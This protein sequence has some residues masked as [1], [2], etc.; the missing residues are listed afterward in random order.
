M[1]QE[2]R[3][4]ATIV[5]RGSVPGRYHMDHVTTVYVKAF[6]IWSLVQ[7]SAFWP[8]A[9][10]SEATVGHRSIVSSCFCPRR[11][12]ALF[13]SPS[14]KLLVVFSST[15]LVA[16]WR[17]HQH[18]M[19]FASELHW[20]L[21]ASVTNLSPRGEGGDVNAQSRQNKCGFKV[22][23]PKTREAGSTKA[24]CT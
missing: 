12:T 1:I 13:W 18:L 5:R 24:Q 2:Q 11:R 7:V 19:S 22:L 3:Q 17:H 21:R 6:P 23:F 20:F 16:E 10:N 8:R 9:G 15:P 14:N 4:S